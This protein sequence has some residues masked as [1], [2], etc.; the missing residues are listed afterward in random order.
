MALDG[1]NLR[2]WYTGQGCVVWGHEIYAW[3]TRDY[4]S[5]SGRLV[6]VNLPTCA[7]TSAPLMT[8]SP[9]DKE[10]NSISH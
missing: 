4:T 9:Q 7:L 8:L 3:G 6:G 2:C 10:S 1:V 5:S